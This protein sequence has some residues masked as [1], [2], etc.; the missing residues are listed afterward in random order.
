MVGTRGFTPIFAMLGSVTVSAGIVVAV[1]GTIVL[2]AVPD[3][4]AATSDPFRAERNACLMPSAFAGLSGLP[5]ERIMNPIDLG[6][7]LLLY[8]PHAVVAAPYHRNEQGVLDAFR[9]FNGPIEA[10][11]AILKARGISLVVIC[12]AMKEIRGLV[13]HT[14]DSFVTLFAEGKLPAWLRDVSLP[15][16]ALKIY[17]VEP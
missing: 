8:T 15:G 3:Y 17:S 5:P 13:D 4:E 14:P 2:A 6:S 16:S 9:F 1:L 12:P 7:H 11:K 10:A